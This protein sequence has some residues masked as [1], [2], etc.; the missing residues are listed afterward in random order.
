MPE[1]PFLLVAVADTAAKQ[2]DLDLA[3]TSARDAL[4][5]LE[6]AERPSHFSAQAWPRIRDG[7]RATALF[8]RAAS[9]AVRGRYRMPNS[10]CSRR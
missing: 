5:Y 9:A 2:R 8:V 10:R 6:H 3:V 4:R 7:M 1:N